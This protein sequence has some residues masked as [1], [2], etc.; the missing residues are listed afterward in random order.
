MLAESCFRLG[1]ADGATG[2]R[3]S[4]RSFVLVQRGGHFLV[5]AW[6]SR[7]LA[8][9]PTFSETFSSFNE[10]VR[11][12]CVKNLSIIEPKE[13]GPFLR[14]SLTRAATDYA[15]DVPDT[16]TMQPRHGRETPP[17]RLWETFQI[18]FKF[19]ITY[20]HISLPR[21]STRPSPSNAGLLL[22]VE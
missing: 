2:L 15:H 14:N 9:T 3:V 19:S 4:F 16:R 13:L 18:H 1:L 5:S 12:L 11:S 10:C 17:S 8:A 7:R 6:P 20:P 21:A 22:V